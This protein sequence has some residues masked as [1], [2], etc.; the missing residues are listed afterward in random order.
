MAVGV[1]WSRDTPQIDST[2]A[3]SLSASFNDPG[4]TY[5]RLSESDSTGNLQLS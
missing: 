1:R 2:E 3:L 4:D 5:E